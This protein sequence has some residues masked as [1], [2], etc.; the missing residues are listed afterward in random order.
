MP[1]IDAITGTTASA[2]DTDD[3]FLLSQD[4]SVKKISTSELKKVLS[5]IEETAVATTTY[6]LLS[7]DQA[8]K[9][10]ASHASAKTFTVPATSG[11][12]IGCPILIRNTAA[13]TLTLL[14][15]TGVTVNASTLDVEEGMTVAL[16]PRA[17]DNWDVYTGSE[18]IG[19]IQ[20]STPT[21]TMTTASSTAIDFSWTNVANEDGYTVQI[22]EDSGFTL[23]VQTATPAADDTAHQFTGLTPS[24][25]YYGRVK[26]EGDGVTYSDSAYG[27]D[28]EVTSAGGLDAD[29]AAYITAEET[30]A[31]IDIDST[32]EN[33]ISALIA[34]LKTDSVWNKIKVLHL[35]YGTG[36][37]NAKSPGTLNATAPN[38]VTIDASGYTFNGTNQYLN[39]ALN[40][41]THLANATEWHAFYVKSSTD[42]KAISGCHDGSSSSYFFPRSTGN[43]LF[44]ISGASDL[45]GGANA[46]AVGTYVFRVR[47]TGANEHTRATKNGVQVYGNAVVSGTSDTPNE[48]E[49]IGAFSN[50]GTPVSHNASTIGIYII[51]GGA[52]NDITDADM[53]NIYTRINTFIT[54]T[55]RT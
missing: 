17:V 37:I 55:S 47:E 9:V 41:N 20:L 52:G 50:V 43:I 21:L 42:D 15:D 27:T 1:T 2:V 6:T 51:G 7:T 16:I 5:V 23:N 25:V 38:G 33:A 29:A 11:F 31:S 8:K 49:Y 10:R 19:L 4:G 18:V 36:L 3:I 46:S 39:T 35:G 54:A 48:V 22:A 44:R 26:A 30:A 45:N 53:G 13:T 14:A 34:G 24:T 28:S 40:P 12:V 32:N